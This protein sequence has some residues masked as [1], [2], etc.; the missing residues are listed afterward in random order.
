[1]AH[2]DHRDERVEKTPNEARQGGIGPHV[3][4]ILAVSTFL[5]AVGL[6]AFFLTT[7]AIT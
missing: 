5:A 3:I 7:A 6:A 2:T 1:M 4:T